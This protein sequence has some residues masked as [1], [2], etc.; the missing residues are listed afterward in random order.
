MPSKSNAGLK[1]PH[2]ISEKWP[3]LPAVIDAA[4]E[5]IMNKKIYFFS[6]ILISSC[7]PISIEQKEQVTFIMIVSCSQGPDSG[8]TQGRMSWDRAAYRSLASPPAFRKW[9]VH[10]SEEKRKSCSSVESTTGGKLRKDENP[11]FLL[12]FVVKYFIFSFQA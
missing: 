5:D 8:C 10:Y 4:F 12:D 7:R 11:S 9:R 3:Q 1:G 6:G 2:V